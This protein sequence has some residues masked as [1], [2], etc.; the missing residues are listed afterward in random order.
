MGPSPSRRPTKAPPSEKIRPKRPPTPADAQGSSPR[1]GPVRARRIKIVVSRADSNL[2]LGAPAS[3]KERLAQWRTDG[4]L[5]AP[6][7]PRHLNT[8]SWVHLLSR[9]VWHTGV[10]AKEARGDSRRGR[11]PSF[12]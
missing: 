3:G 1:L 11:G 12:P 4:P 7:G 2:F 9:A 5:G 6:L 10:R 8:S